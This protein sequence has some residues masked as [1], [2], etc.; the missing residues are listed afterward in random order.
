MKS[1]YSKISKH[2]DFSKIHT[3]EYQPVNINNEFKF[4]NH[5]YQISQGLEQYKVLSYGNENNADMDIVYILHQ[6][7]KLKYFDQNG[8]LIKSKYITIVA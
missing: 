6:E 4:N 1:T 5:I 8:D 3:L 7:D 2:I